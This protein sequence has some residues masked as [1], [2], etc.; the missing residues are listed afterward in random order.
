MN[1]AKLA[2]ELGLTK[3]DREKILKFAIAL[4]QQESKPEWLPTADALLEFK[5]TKV[6]SKGIS[7]D[8]LKSR[9]MSGEF[10]YAVHYINAIDSI[11]GE[12]S[13]YLWHTEA[14]I[15]LWKTPPEQRTRTQNMAS[16]RKRVLKTA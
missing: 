5:G 7:S 11:K 13:F 14:I 4:N 6:N 1:I 10:Q 12:K 16:S 3:D 2:K 9:V 8:M 15:E